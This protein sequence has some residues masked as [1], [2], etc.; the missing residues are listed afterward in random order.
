MTE[1]HLP[2]HHEPRTYADRFEAGDEL[3]RRV[4]RHLIDHPNRDYE[5]AMAIVL[6]EDADLK[7]AY[8][9]AD[10]GSG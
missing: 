3:D 2:T 4:Q 10:P 6:D 9:Y 5:A 1:L 7:A 8:A